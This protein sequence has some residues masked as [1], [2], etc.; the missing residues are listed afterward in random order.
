MSAKGWT[1]PRGA[2]TA[3]YFIVEGGAFVVSSLCG[4]K[5][6][7]PTQAAA[8]NASYSGSDRCQACDKKRVKLANGEATE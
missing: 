7:L 8:L 2:R 3:C 4:K 5:S 1:F 6:I